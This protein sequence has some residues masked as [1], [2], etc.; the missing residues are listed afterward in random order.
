MSLSRFALFACF[1]AD[2]SPLCSSFFA[3][4]F[5]GF[6]SGKSSLPSS[7]LRL[8][9]SDLTTLSLLCSRWYPFLPR[10]TIRVYSRT[11]KWF[12][13]KWSLRPRSI[14]RLDSIPLPLLPRFLPHHVRSLL[15]LH[16]SFG[17]KVLTERSLGTATGVSA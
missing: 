14:D 11:S 6:M 15:P 8:P 10:R 3:V 2:N 4:A 9:P 5:L 12:V 13:R 16:S 7:S 1:A 17:Y